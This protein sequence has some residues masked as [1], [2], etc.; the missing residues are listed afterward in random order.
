V[1]DNVS[2]VRK[3]PSVVGTGFSVMP[4][5]FHALFPGIVPDV[6][7]QALQMGA[8]GDCG[9]HKKVGTVVHV[10]QIHHDHR[11][12]AMVLDEGGKFKGEGLV[13]RR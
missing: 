10:P 8:A 9:N 2:Q 5:Y 13:I 6:P 7:L 4:E 12:P 3:V 11:F 1:N